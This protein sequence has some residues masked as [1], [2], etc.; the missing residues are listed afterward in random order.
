MSQRPAGPGGFDA[1]CS[2]AGQ[3]I[4]IQD[5]QAAIGDVLFDHVQGHPAPSQSVLEK[6][7]LGR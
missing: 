4:G 5:L 1:W 3:L 7:V 2:G 6:G